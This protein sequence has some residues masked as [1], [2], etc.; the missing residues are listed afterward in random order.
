M[1]LQF[2]S[3]AVHGLLDYIAAGALIVLPVLLGLTGIAF[4]MSVAG[5]LGL[6][7]YSLLTDYRLGA[8][9]LLSFDLHLLLDLAAAVAFIAA[10]FV[11]RFD[12]FTSGYD[13]VM[14]G[15]V[16]AVVL[17]SAR[18]ARRPDTAVAGATGDK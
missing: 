9:R 18:T 2:L 12:A 17:A 11:F 14:G 10:P 13:F 3:P 7:A 5:G 6:I 1:K 15:G 4:W 8:V 16:V